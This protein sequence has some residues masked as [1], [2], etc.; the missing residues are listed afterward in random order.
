MFGP[1]VGSA[2][3]ELTSFQEMSIL[4]GGF[5]VLVSPLMLINSGLPS[6]YVEVLLL[7]LLLLLVGC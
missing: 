7:L 3:Y 1:L 4:L 2:I 6:V 5:M